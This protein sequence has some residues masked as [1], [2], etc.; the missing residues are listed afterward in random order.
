MCMG[1]GAPQPKVWELPEP[2]LAFRA[3]SPVGH[4]AARRGEQ[5]WQ[6]FGGVVGPA[7]R[8]C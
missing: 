8:P 7:Y 4:V 6:D 1:L 3:D 5:N 2:C